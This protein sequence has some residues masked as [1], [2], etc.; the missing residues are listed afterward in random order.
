MNECMN[1]WMKW[2]EMKWN[3]MKW[4]DGWMDGWMH[5]HLFMY[6]ITV[7]K[8]RHGKNKLDDDVF[9][10]NITLDYHSPESPLTHHGGDSRIG[11]FHIAGTWFT[12]VVVVRVAIS[13]LVELC[14]SNRESNCP[15]TYLD[16]PRGKWPRTVMISHCDFVALIR[17]FSWVNP[18]FSS[19]IMLFSRF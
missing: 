17:H 19:S 18:W 5:A 7:R 6:H 4:M 14:W 9:R 10:G 13:M 16:D 11:L 8:N 1:E 15:L 12:M 2:N 3:E